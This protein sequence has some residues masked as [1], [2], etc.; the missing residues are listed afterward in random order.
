MLALTACAGAPPGDTEDDRMEYLEIL[1]RLEAGGP[2]LERGS[3]A[4]SR[5]IERFESLLSDFKAPD[6]VDRVA[7]V[8]A[9]TAFFNDT[10]K[11][12]RGAEAIREYLGVTAEA[13]DRGTVEFLD[14]VADDGNYYFRWLMTLRFKRFD[15]GEDKRSIGMSHIRFD[16]EGR[17]VLH[18]DYWDSSSGLFE[19]VPV[20]GWMLERV[21][22]RL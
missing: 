13:V 15:A 16:A 1:E 10:L 14:L 7:E 17:V 2:P 11:T 19:H 9:E 8:Y 18:Q 20:L 6:F 22:K 3:A 5:A 4:E 12:V 21:K